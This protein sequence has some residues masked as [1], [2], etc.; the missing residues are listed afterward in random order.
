MLAKLKDKEKLDFSIGDEKPK[1]SGSSGSSGGKSKYT[2]EDRRN[3][4]KLMLSGG[5]KKSKINNFVKSKP[6]VKSKSK[7]KPKAKSTKSKKTCPCMLNK[8]GSKKK[9][10]KKCSCHA[11]HAYY[12]KKSVGEKKK[13]IIKS[14]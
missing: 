1:S 6:K 13:I 14:L 3:F 7:A 12:N 2:D 9:K 11:E 8:D 4:F 5:S 10:K